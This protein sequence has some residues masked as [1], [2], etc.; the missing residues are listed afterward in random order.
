MRHYRWAI[1]AYPPRFRRRHGGEII[2]TAVDLS[3]GRWSLRQALSLLL[4][5][6][7]MSLRSPSRYWGLAVLIPVAY[8]ALF[9]RHSWSGEVDDSITVW[10]LKIATIPSLL[11]LATLVGLHVHDQP[12]RWR[13]VAG[14]WA[15]GGIAVVAAAARVAANASTTLSDGAYWRIWPDS[16]LDVSLSPQEWGGTADP[17]TVS[18]I[19]THEII[20]AILL[21][22]VS[23][24]AIRLA[25]KSPAMTFLVLPVAVAGVLV[26]YLVSTPWVL[27]IGAD[28]YVG[29]AILGSVFA[30]LMFFIAP[31]DPVGAAALAAAA[32]TMGLQILSWGGSAAIAWDQPIGQSAHRS[33]RAA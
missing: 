9:A 25:A 4:G 8:A 5:G 21:A 27:A 22:V 32:L 30:E 20:V 15:V 16:G 31:F 28:F 23:A 3:D 6:L 29:D 18:E 24:I 26:T 2:D 13:G 19:L 14:I 10:L 7:R 1:R 12:A 33:T 17:P 11:A